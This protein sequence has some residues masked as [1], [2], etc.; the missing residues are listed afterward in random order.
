MK[1]RKV[2]R[3]GAGPFATVIRAVFTVIYVVPLLWILLT[4][5]KQ[6]KDVLNPSKAIFFSP[7]LDA[8]RGVVEGGLTTALGQSL[9]IAT[10]ATMIVVVIAVPAAYA[11]ARL[12]GALVAASLFILIMLQMLPQTSTVIPLFQLFGSIGFLDTNA[13][14]MLADAAL[15]TPFSI[16]LLRP[17]FRNVPMALEEAASIDGASS[18][19]TFFS[20]VLPI[21]RNGIATTSVVVFLI[22]W[23]EFLYAVNFFQNPINYPLSAL[24]AQQV[25]SYGINWPGMMALGVV[26]AIPIIIIFSASYRLLREGLSVGAVK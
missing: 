22:I 13:A 8:Y 23:G 9:A 17:F 21:V 24:L 5:F 7:T 15:M 11:L 26:S 20:I 19:R 14:V 6:S 2:R 25:S 10:V 3:L 4:S 12:N 16:I 18:M 1:S